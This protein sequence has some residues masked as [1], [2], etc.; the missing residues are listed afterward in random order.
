[1]SPSISSLPS[2]YSYF[3]TAGSWTTSTPSVPALTLNWW[4]KGLRGAQEKPEWRLECPIQGHDTEAL[5]TAQSQGEAGPPS[6]C[7]FLRARKFDYD[8]AL[9]LLLLGF[10]V[11]S[12]VFQD[13]SSHSEAT[14]WIGLSPTRPVA[15]QAGD[16]ILASAR[17]ERQVNTV[18]SSWPTSTRM[19]MS[20]TSNQ[21]RSL[22][23]VVSILRVALHCLVS[24][25]YQQTEHSLLSLSGQGVE[26]EQKGSDAKALL[27]ERDEHHLW[28]RETTAPFQNNLLAQ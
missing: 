19:G 18:S 23:K 27:L 13:L 4:P 22:Q 10:L 8:R 6:S 3:R 21:A 2:S 25:L 1:M 17:G 16:L 24:S 9:Q 5:G 12:P 11:C 20:Q 14:S 15:D 26:A 7:T 28:A